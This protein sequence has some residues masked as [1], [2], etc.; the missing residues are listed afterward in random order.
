LGL[1]HLQALILLG[2]LEDCGYCAYLERLHGSYAGRFRVAV[3][4]PQ[5]TMVLFYYSEAELLPLVTR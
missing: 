1:N 2:E 4:L 3:K 5:S